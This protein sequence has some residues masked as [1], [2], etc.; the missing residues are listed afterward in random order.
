MR[1][2]R[3]VGLILLLT[4]FTANAEDHGIWNQISTLNGGAILYAAPSTLNISK[5]DKTISYKML[6]NEPATKRVDKTFYLSMVWDVFAD[7]KS[8]YGHVRR[9]S[10]YSG[11]FASGSSVKSYGNND[12]A[13]LDKS[14]P[15]GGM[16]LALCHDSFR[17]K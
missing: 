2:S 1:I 7:C 3:A 6:I 15:D 8:E 5:Q 10:F 12:S 13:P 17:S 11:K 9:V 4:S 16:S 14:R